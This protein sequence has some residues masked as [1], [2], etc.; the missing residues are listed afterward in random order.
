MY[1]TFPLR[2]AAF[3]AP[4]QFVSSAV[5]VGFFSSLL[6]PPDPPHPVAET[7]IVAVIRNASVFL[8]VFFFISSSPFFSGVLSLMPGHK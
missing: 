2:S 1:V 6:S 7:A 3:S 4:S 8:N 5:F